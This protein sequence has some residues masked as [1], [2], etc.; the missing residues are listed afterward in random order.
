MQRVCLYAMLSGK[1]HAATLFAMSALPRVEQISRRGSGQKRRTPLPPTLGR[2]AIG[3]ANS[4]FGGGNQ[5]AS[6]GRKTVVARFPTHR[7]A[8]PVR[9]ITANY[10]EL[11]SYYA[12]VFCDH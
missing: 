9:A 3:Q 7:T 4:R 1:D 10:A 6:M 2:F 5:P 11:R 8:S 12:A